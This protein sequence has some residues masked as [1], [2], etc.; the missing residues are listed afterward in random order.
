[1]DEIPEM[2]SQMFNVTIHVPS[3][4]PT[5]R[6]LM[7]LYMSASEIPSTVHIPI[8]VYVDVP[9]LELVD[10]KVD[11]GRVHFPSELA[12]LYI[13]TTVNASFVDMTDG[14]RATL[15]YRTTSGNYLSLDLSA[16]VDS[17]SVGLYAVEFEVPINATSC[18]LVVQI[19]KYIEDTNVLYK[20][21]AM[22]SFDICYTLS[23]M[24]AILISVNGTTATIN[25]I[26][27]TIEAN[28]TSLD[29]R[30]TS[31]IVNSKDEIIAKIDTAIGTIEA[32]AEAIG[33]KVTLIEG[34]VT[35]IRTSLGEIRGTIETINDDV[36]TVKT[37]VG[38]IK[39]NV[40]DIEGYVANIPQTSW[41]IWAAIA[42]SLIAAACSTVTL[43]LLRKKPKT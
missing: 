15:W 11:V 2:G 5:G 41:T 38:T 32:S 40:E 37:D 42:F 8:F 28:L 31:L 27:G 39:V 7:A 6:Y 35:A 22:A 34:N 4:A 13:M 25:T 16:A 23:A 30:L 14:V 26:V 3:D 21:V 43:L 36:A 29:A 10:V 20:G 24:N 18:C 33:L 19:E 9:N 17:I 1:V 12:Q